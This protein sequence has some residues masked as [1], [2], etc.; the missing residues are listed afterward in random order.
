MTFVTRAILGDLEICFQRPLQVIGCD[1]YN[2]YLADRFRKI[3][4]LSYIQ[5]FTKDWR[6]VEASTGHGIFFPYRTK[7]H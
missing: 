1:E 2:V 5:T 6:F 7:E 4:G 3:D